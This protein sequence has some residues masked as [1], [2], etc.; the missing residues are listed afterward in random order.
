MLRQTRDEFK[1]DQIFRLFNSC[2]HQVFCPL[3]Y[4][5]R[6]SH[7]SPTM[8]YERRSKCQMFSFL[9]LRVGPYGFQ[10]KF[11]Q[12]YRETSMCIPLVDVFF[13]SCP[14]CMDT[15]RKLST[16][17]VKICWYFLIH[18]WESILIN[19]LAASFLL[20]PMVDYHWSYIPHIFWNETNRLLAET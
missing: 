10:I 20:E 5:P 15:K 16:G 12:R 3:K 6:R 7:V 14:L 11:Y 1:M 2:L 4:S 8:F 18:T 9:F 17:W 19:V 13:P